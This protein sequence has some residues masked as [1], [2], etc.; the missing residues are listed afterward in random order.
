MD[1][2]IKEN[3]IDNV[4]IVDNTKK[5]DN[6]TIIEK[7]IS[8]L[9]NKNSDL[10][11]KNAELIK[12]NEELI[13]KVGKKSVSF[14]DKNKDKNIEDDK[15]KKEIQNLKQLIAKLYTDIKDKTYKIKELTN[16]N[17]NINTT[18]E[19]SKE[20]LLKTNNLYKELQQ[21]CNMLEKENIELKNK[22][23]NTPNTKNKVI[24]E[25]ISIQNKEIQEDTII[26]ES[27]NDNE[28]EYLLQPN[29]EPI[30]FKG[31]KEMLANIK[32][33]A[34]KS[35]NNIKDK[36]ELESLKNKILLNNYEPPKTQ[37]TNTTNTTNTKN[38][39]PSNPKTKQ[40]NRRVTRLFFK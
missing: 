35:T 20:E 14:E 25:K 26:E 13:K 37:I 22:V 36:T 4:G 39:Q 17:E 5:N 33:E 1:I 38:K 18:L 7:V 6:M 11:S 34:R 24:P 8:G 32:E 28:T 23:K 15:D 12:I 9:K 19:E 30:K 29:K 31:L 2:E 10:E 40:V 3:S 21:K 27:A 16:S